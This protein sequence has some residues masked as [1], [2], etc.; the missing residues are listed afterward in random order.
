MITKPY[1]F[2]GEEETPE[3]P[4]PDATPEEAKPEEVTA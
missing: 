1:L 2:D 4:E 3:T